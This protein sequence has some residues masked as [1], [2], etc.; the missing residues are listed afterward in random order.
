[1]SDKKRLVLQFA[2]HG[3][4]PV[5]V[6]G[7]NGPVLVSPPSGGAAPIFTTNE[8]QEG[9]FS[10]L[11]G[12]LWV[13]PAGSVEAGN[14]EVLHSGSF[15]FVGDVAQMLHDG[16]ANDGKLSSGE[17]AAIMAKLAGHAELPAIAGDF[18]SKLRG[19]AGLAK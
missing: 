12:P 3:A 13:V 4:G 7:G 8:W 11:K 18:I 15:A 2:G 1:M 17:I 10:E 16:L 6:Q 14:P 5:P 9:M 19:L